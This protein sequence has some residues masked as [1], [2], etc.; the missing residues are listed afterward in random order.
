MSKLV[1]PQA[2]GPWTRWWSSTS[3][4][5]KNSGAWGVP[6]AFWMA[7]RCQE[8]EQDC[9]FRDE[10]LLRIW[11]HVNTKKKRFLVPIGCHNPTSKE[12]RRIQFRVVVVRDWIW[13]PSYPPPPLFCP[14]AYSS[15]ESCLLQGYGLDGWKAWSS[16]RLVPQLTPPSPFRCGWRTT[17]GQ[18]ITSRSR[19]SPLSRYNL[20]YVIKINVMFV[21]FSPDWKPHEFFIRAKLVGMDLPKIC[22]AT[23]QQQLPNVADKTDE[24]KQV[25]SCSS[26]C[27]S[28][29]SKEFCHDLICGRSTHLNS[30]EISKS[31]NTVPASCNILPGIRLCCGFLPVQENCLCE[32][33][34]RKKIVSWQKRMS[35]FVCG[36]NSEPKWGCT[37]FT[38][39][40]ENF[41]R[42]H[43]MADHPPRKMHTLYV[44]KGK[45]ICRWFE[46]GHQPQ[47]RDWQL[48]LHCK[49]AAAVLHFI[50]NECTLFLFYQIW[51]CVA[52]SS[53]YHN[54]LIDFYQGMLPCIF[55]YLKCFHSPQS[56]FNVDSHTGTLV[57]QLVLFP[58]KLHISW[59]KRR[60]NQKPSSAINV[61]FSGRK[62]FVRQDCISLLKVISQPTL[63]CHFSVSCLPSKSPRKK[64]YFPSTDMTN[65]IVY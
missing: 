48:L 50:N 60:H 58:K 51:L 19:L 15:T 46:R 62:S 52:C 11:T 27:A 55:Q 39:R 47:R 13:R 40:L 4:L 44:H 65:F 17:W 14:M 34:S 61:W 54:D 36:R 31:A 25:I 2:S 32:E 30:K 23:A 22:V 49:Y 45:S 42:S 35:A 26:A 43:L 37:I 33:T 5:A 9:F 57:G 59:S 24:W 56:S 12:G 41:A 63:S 38:L 10:K 53:N 16:C 29:W 7:C 21:S 6:I 1:T 20:S 64:H 3:Y 18:P 28:G 8:H